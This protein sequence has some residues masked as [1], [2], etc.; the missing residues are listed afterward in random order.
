MT[1]RLAKLSRRI[2]MELVDI[3]QSVA[4]AQAGWQEYQRSGD[5]LYLDSV[6]LNLHSFYNGI[7]RLFEGI[8]TTLDNHLPS[9]SGWHKALLEQMANEV[10]NVRPAV[11]SDLTLTLLDNYC[12]FRHVVRNIY[13]YRIDP[14]KLSHLVEEVPGTFA[15]AQQELTDFAGW[16]A[17][18]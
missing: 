8:A 6:A 7:E 9:G 14:D 1:T 17:K 4:R 15:Q 13:S 3:K 2:Q 11:I 10:A 18:F 5:D 16:L 12:R